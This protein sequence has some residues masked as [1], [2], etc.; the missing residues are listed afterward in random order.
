MSGHTGK[1]AM[2]E[3]FIVRELTSEGLSVAQRYL[4]GV[5]ENGW[6]PLPGGLLT[7]DAY[8][9]PAASAVYVESHRF[10]G[11]REAGQYLA[12]RL[13]PLGATRIAENAP[14]WSW[15]GMFYLDETTRG[16]GGA[17]QYAEIAH[18]IDPAKHNR[19][20]RSHHRLKMAYD[21]WTLHGEDAWWLLDQPVGSMGQFTLRIVQAPELFRSRE[22]VRLVLSLYV[23]A[24]TGAMRPGTRGQDLRSAPAGSLPRLF[25]ALAQLSM[26]Y[27]VYGSMTSSQVLDLLPS[28]FDRFR[29]SAPVA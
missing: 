23:D 15:L 22:L 9:Q 8:A 29:P 2:G 10:A 28:E 26:T 20:D 24:S 16:G 11:K 6:T 18:L 1:G 5:R 4:K 12:E 27:D 21:I 13:G 25:N 17:V 3:A 19:L 7:D 14:L